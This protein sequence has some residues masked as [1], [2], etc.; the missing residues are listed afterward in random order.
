VNPSDPTANAA[1]RSGDDDVLGFALD[2]LDEIDAVFIV[3]RDSF[4]VPIAGLVRFLKASSKNV[5]PN[6]DYLG[7]VRSMLAGAREQLSRAIAKSGLVREDLDWQSS[8]AVR[9]IGARHGVNLLRPCGHC[10]Q[11]KISV[12]GSMGRP[13]EYCSNSCRQAAYRRR[14]AD[15]VGEA[16]LDDPAKAC[17][18]ASQELSDVSRTV[19]DSDSSN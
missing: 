4:E 11:Q 19:D 7:H 17:C 16:A 13:R 18:R 3:L 6:Y 1:I 8:R 10:L 12:G 5:I 15:T 9:D 14:Q 2:E